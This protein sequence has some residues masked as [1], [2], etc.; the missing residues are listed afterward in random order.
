MWR[1]THSIHR[2]QYYLQFQAPTGGPVRYLLWIRGNY[3]NNKIKQSNTRMK[4]DEN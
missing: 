3:Y 1:R 2:V 4:N